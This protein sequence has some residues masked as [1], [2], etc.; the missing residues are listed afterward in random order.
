MKELRP[1]VFFR[2]RPKDAGLI[3]LLRRVEVPIEAGRD[4]G[5]AAAERL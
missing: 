2:R 3:A 1:I 5:P 4:G